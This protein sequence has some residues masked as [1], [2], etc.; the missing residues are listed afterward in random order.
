MKKIITTIAFSLFVATQ[1]FAA[2]TIDMPADLTA[3]TTVTGGTLFGDKTTA[4]ASTTLIGKTSTGVALAAKTG[5]GGYAMVTQHKS[6]NRAFAT[7]YDSTSV[8]YKDV[9]SVGTAVKSTVTKSDATEFSSWNS[10]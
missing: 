7:S 9:V 1:A 5:T 8:F 10:M 6:G 4:T 2:A 3:A